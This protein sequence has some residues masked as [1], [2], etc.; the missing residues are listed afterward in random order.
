M[1]GGGTEKKNK[2][3]LQASSLL[4]TTVPV[5]DQLQLVTQQEQ[6]T[7]L[8][9]GGLATEK[10][11]QLLCCQASVMHPCHTDAIVLCSNKSEDFATYAKPNLGS[12]NVM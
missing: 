4:P 2:I 6:L 5:R 12:R 3:A 7:K 11:T 1:G 8:S 10:R 9:R